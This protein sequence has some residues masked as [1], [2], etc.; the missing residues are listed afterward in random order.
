MRTDTAPRSEAG[1]GSEAAAWY[2][3]VATGRVIRRG[4]RKAVSGEAAR[5]TE[6]DYEGAK[7]WSTGMSESSQEQGETSE[8]PSAGRSGPAAAGSSAST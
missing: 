7:R 4:P 6:E 8:P 1:S 2:V 3:D 5:D